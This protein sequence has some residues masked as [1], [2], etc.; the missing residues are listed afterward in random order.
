MSEFDHRRRVEDWALTRREL[1]G[2]LGNGFAA[3]GMGGL[4]TCDA[5]ASGCPVAAALNPL[6]TNSPDF[7]EL[8]NVRP[9]FG[10]SEPA[11]IHCDVPARI[12]DTGD[13]KLAVGVPSRRFP[14]NVYRPGQNGP[15]K[16]HRAYPQQLYAASRAARTTRSPTK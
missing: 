14:G 16:D 1:P 3:L 7:A 12:S 9:R 6:P 13:P 4:L 5:A 10:Q 11:R 15:R 2:R 8:G